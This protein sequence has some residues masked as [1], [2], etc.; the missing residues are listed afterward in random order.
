LRIDPALAAGVIL[1]M[2]TD[3]IGF[4]AAGSRYAY[5]CCDSGGR[6]AGNMMVCSS[7]TAKKRQ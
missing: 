5:S 4:D 7:L 2:L 6:S 3:C 1:T